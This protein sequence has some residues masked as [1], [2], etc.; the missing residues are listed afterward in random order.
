[1]ESP[2]HRWVAAYGGVDKLAKELGVTSQVVKY[3]LR[4]RGWPKVKNILDIVRLSGGKLTFE[5]VVNGTKPRAP[6]RP[7]RV[8]S[9]KKK[10]R[11]AR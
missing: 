6:K 10:A 7:V 11:V 4:R 8:A 9:K 2:F 5:D 1:M 3:W